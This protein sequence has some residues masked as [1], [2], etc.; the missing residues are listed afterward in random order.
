[1]QTRQPQVVNGQITETVIENYLTV[2][3]SA[4]AINFY[5]SN[6]PENISFD[7]VANKAKNPPFNTTLM[8]GALPLTF[9]ETW[10]QNLFSMTIYYAVD[11]ADVTTEPNGFKLFNSLVNT[12]LELNIHP[13]PPK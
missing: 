6:F 1:M 5:N 13:R 11:I 3:D 8:I 7:L 12:S 10:M 4:A 9:L 2:V